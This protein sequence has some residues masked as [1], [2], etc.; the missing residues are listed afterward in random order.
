MI[1]AKVNWLSTVRTVRLQLALID[2]PFDGLVEAVFVKN[3]VHV[4]WQLDNSIV[5]LEV[6][7]TDITRLFSKLFTC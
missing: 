3:M 1:F 7:E 5:V 6:Y 4:A 2:L